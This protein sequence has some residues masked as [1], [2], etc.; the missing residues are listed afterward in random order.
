MPPDYGR[1]QRDFVFTGQRDDG[2][3]LAV[4][5][6]G[7]SSRVPSQELR[8]THPL[9]KLTVGRWLARHAVGASQTWRDRNRVALEVER[10]MAGYPQVLQVHPPADAPRISVVGNSSRV[11]QQAVSIGQDTMRDVLAPALVG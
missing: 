4:V 6:E 10:L 7:G 5:L 2:A 1:P 8:R 3:R 9:R 11:Q